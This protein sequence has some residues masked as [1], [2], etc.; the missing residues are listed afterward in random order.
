MNEITEVYSPGTTVR[1]QTGIDAVVI[2]V[3]L[4]FGGVQYRVQWMN[5]GSLNDTYVSEFLLERQ[6]VPA[7]R[8]IGYKSG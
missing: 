5:A 7:T 4:G 6:V 2:Q 8:K 3:I 1:L